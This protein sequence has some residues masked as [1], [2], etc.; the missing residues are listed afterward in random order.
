[1]TRANN[2]LQVTYMMWTFQQ[3]IPA[4]IHHTLTITTTNLCMLRSRVIIGV[5]SKLGGAGVTWK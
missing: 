2:D 3:F 1:M 5:T 4:N